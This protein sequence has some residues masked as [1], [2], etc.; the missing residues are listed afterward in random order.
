MSPTSWLR[1]RCEWATCRRL[2]RL[3]GWTF[4]RVDLSQC[5]IWCPCLLL[6]LPRFRRSYLPHTITHLLQLGPHPPSL[7]SVLYSACSRFLFCLLSETLLIYTLPCP[8]DLVSVVVLPLRCP[9][10]DETC[11]FGSVILNESYQTTWMTWNDGDAALAF[12]SA[13]VLDQ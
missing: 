4:I 12:I 8:R 6:P 10:G 5:F 9:M 13:G 3:G 1:R 7:S 2:H 11:T